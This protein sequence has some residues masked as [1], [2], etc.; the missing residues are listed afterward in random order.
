GGGGSGGGEGGEGEAGAEGG[1]RPGRGAGAN[2]GRRQALRS[3]R[4]HAALPKSAVCLFHGR[5]LAEHRRKLGVLLAVGQRAVD[6]RPV[7]FAL[8]IGP[9]ARQGICVSHGRLEACQPRSA[10]TRSARRG[11]GRTIRAAAA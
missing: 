9:I 2:G 8:E 10:E 7:D 1:A 5:K 11:T 4:P 3:L 6:R